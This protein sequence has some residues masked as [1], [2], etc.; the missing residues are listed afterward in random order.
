MNRTHCL[1]RWSCRSLIA[2]VALVLLLAAVSHAQVSL[3]QLT[4][5]KLDKTKDLVVDASKS[6]KDKDKPP[7]SASPSLI[8]VSCC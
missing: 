7:K 2:M 8:P 4:K 6:S 3:D 5:Q 1:L